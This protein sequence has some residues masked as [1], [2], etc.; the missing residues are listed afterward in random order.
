MGEPTRQSHITVA[1]GD[2]PVFLADHDSPSAA[3]GVIVIPSIYGPNDDLLTD[4]TGLT[5]LASTVVLDPFWREG[6]GA[7]DYFDRD[8]AVGRLGSFDPARCQTDVAAVAAWMR[9]RTN[10]RLVGVG[11]CF[12]GPYVLKG[13]SEGWL[14]AG[15]TWHGSRLERTLAD[16]EPFEAPLRI[17]FGDADPVTPPEAIDAVRQHFS[18]HPDCQISIHQGGDHGFSFHGPAW[19]PLAAAACIATLRELVQG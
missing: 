14:S 6:G 7:V 9:G 4:M 13:A 19:D 16:L 15:A 1:D 8:R 12:G 18:S 2:I 3:P 10:G 17:H 5:D 11:I